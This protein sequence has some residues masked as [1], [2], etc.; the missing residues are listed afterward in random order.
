MSYTIILACVIGLLIGLLA[1]AF[2]KKNVVVI[3]CAALLAVITGMFA[4]KVSG[5]ISRTA[6]VLGAIAVVAIVIQLLY[7]FVFKKNIFE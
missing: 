7:K 3:P 5:S 2:K 1:G 4:Y 6:I